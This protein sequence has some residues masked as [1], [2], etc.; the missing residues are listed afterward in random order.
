MK[1][2]WSIKW[3]Q[4]RSTP[5]FWKPRMD[6]LRYLQQPLTARRT[7]TCQC[8]SVWICAADNRR[9]G[10]YK[11]AVSIWIASL[12]LK[13]SLTRSISSFSKTSISIM[14]SI[15]LLSVA[16][17]ALVATGNALQ[18][19]PVLCL[20]ACPFGFEVDSQGCPYCSCRVSP[21]TCREPIFGYNCGSI[22]HRECPSSHECQLGFSGF[23]GQCCLKPTGTSTT[24]RPTTARATT[25]R[26]TTARATTTGSRTT[27][28]RVFK[29]FFATSAASVTGTGAQETGA[30]GT[31]LPAG[32]TPG[33]AVTTGGWSYWATT[34]E[35]WYRF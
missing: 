2:H 8:I 17:F 29:R 19:S 9:L 23:S 1:V 26:S 11:I 25:S 20:I 21:A 3:W 18:C 4:V 32:T 24:P 27:S 10:V 6:F 35:V 34:T 28:G 22:D 5:R 33:S 16:L 31:G 7:I 12:F 15:G 13:V 14:Y 30:Q